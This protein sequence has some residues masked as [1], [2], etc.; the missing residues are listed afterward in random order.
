MARTS[1]AR[2]KKTAAPG[3]AVRKKAAAA[4]PKKAAKKAVSRAI[5]ARPRSA[6]KLSKST[7]RARWIEST[8]DHEDRPGQS[9]AT[10]AML[11]S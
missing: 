11:S 7:M 4:R 6:G 3:K 8:G 10:R 1:A 9:L 2:T 5:S